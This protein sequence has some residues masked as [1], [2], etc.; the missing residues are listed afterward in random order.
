MFCTNTCGYKRMNA[1]DFGESLTFLVKGR[2][3]KLHK[4]DFYLFQF[5][6]ENNTDSLSY[7]QKKSFVFR[8]TEKREIKV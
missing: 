4:F 1:N 3:K 5:V 8:D 7:L 6:A 2:H